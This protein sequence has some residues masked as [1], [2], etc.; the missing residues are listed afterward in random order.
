M[1]I[2][3]LY[4]CSIDMKIGYYYNCKYTALLNNLFNKVVP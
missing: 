4:Y 3:I 1:S 2:D